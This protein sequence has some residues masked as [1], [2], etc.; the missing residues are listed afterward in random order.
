MSLMENFRNLRRASYVTNDKKNVQS[1]L[2]VPVYLKLREFA[3]LHSYSLAQAIELIIEKFLA[4]R[5]K[6]NEEVK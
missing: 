2:D 6:S 4:E 1:Q 3:T 5:S